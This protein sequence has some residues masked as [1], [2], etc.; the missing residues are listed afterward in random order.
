MAPQR[1]KVE[2]HPTT[3]I[4]NITGAKLQKEIQTQTTV[5]ALI[6]KGTLLMKV[7]SYL[8]YN[9]SRMSLKT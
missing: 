8:Y 9:P 2:V 6:V 3:V 5:L 1:E 4:V 7:H